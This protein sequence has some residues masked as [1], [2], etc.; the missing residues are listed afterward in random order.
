M[1]TEK[2]RDI[3]A[4]LTERFRECT[5]AIGTD[6]RGLSAKQMTELR[7][8]RREKSVRYLVVKNRLALLAAKEAG[9]DVF[10]QLL[11]GST[12]IAFGQGEPSEAA[13]A[14]D[15]YIKST[16]SALVVR[17]AVMDGE[18]LSAAQVAVLASLPSKQELLARLL[19]QMNAPIEGLVNV[20]SGPIRAL[21]IVLQRRGEQLAA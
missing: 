1:P 13:K 6:F 5:V 8:R 12:G 10:A 14:V 17:S 7:Q 11:E 2:K 21:A 9:M 16:R 20:L 18:L 15:E 4:V 19:G 3:V